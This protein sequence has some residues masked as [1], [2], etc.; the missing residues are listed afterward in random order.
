LISPL[1][2]LVTF[3]SA[4]HPA[5]DHIPRLDTIRPNLD[6]VLSALL[7]T[8]AINVLLIAR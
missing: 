4:W 7:P 5:E 1:P 2:R 8:V 3:T 6:R